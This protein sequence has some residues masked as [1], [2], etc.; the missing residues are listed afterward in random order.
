MKGAAELLG[1]SYG[2]LY[3][4]YRETFGYL[5]HAWNKPRSGANAQ[6]QQ[7]QQPQSSLIS[8]TLPLPL[9][10]GEQDNVIE[11]LRSGKINMKQ[12][13]TLLG[14]DTSML[15]YQLTGKVRAIAV[16][17]VVGLSIFEAAFFLPFLVQ[18]STGFFLSYSTLVAAENLGRRK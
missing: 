11:L 2:T 18:I 15:A 17:Y 3:G 8:P 4:R 16:R 1:V 12:A 5:K 14:I 7:Q 6:Q 10:V 9:D 13:A